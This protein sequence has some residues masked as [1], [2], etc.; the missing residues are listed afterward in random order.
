MTERLRRYFIAALSEFLAREAENI[1]ATT[2]ER[3]WCFRLGFYME[4]MRPSWLPEMY[5]VDAEYNRK[6]HGRVKTIQGVNGKPLNITPDIILHSRG[7]SIRNDNLIA[8]EMKKSGQPLAEKNADR[9]RLIIMTSRRHDEFMPDPRVHPEHVC[10]YKL[11]F[12]IVLDPRNGDVAV[13]TY[14]AG[15]L[16]REDMYRF[17][18]NA[19]D[20]PARPHGLP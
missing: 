16:V 6:Q 15:N 11:G 8:I 17:A 20:A 12:F 13:E 3:N 1:T 10:G 19:Q 18:E 4:L 5:V 14:A 2:S 9:N 7:R